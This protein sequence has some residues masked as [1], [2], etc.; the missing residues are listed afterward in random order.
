MYAHMEGQKL[1]LDIV[2]F[3][4]LLYLLRQGHFLNP[5]HANSASLARQLAPGNPSPP[6]G[7]WDDRL[8]NT[9]AQL[10]GECWGSELCSSHLCGKHFIHLTTPQPPPPVRAWAQA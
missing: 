2:D 1:T 3:F 4:L 10:F 9:E 8:A 7:T 6:P 5:E